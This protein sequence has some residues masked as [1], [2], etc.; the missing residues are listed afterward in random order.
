MRTVSAQRHESAKMA[1]Q[2]HSRKI[3][4]RPHDEYHKEKVLNPGNEIFVKSTKNPAFN[5]F[6]RIVEAQSK[7]GGWRVPENE[8]N[9][10]ALWGGFPGGWAGRTMFRH[11][12]QKGYFVLVLALSS[13]IHLG[14][15]DWLFFPVN[16]GCLRIKYGDEV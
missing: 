5:V 6:Y 4:E 11:N 14:L 10:L 9:G 1:V 3:N 15:A 16:R 2:R 7:A 8:L 12:T 13:V